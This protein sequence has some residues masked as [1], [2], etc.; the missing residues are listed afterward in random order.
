MLTKENG[1]QWKEQ[2]TKLFE[3]LLL[4]THQINRYYSS[5]PFASHLISSH[6]ISPH[7][8]MSFDCKTFPN[9]NTIDFKANNVPLTNIWRVDHNLTIH[10]LCE[11]LILCKYIVS[12][13]SWSYCSEQSVSYWNIFYWHKTRPKTIV[14]HNNSNNGNNYLFCSVRKILQILMNV[15]CWNVIN[16]PIVGSQSVLFLFNLGWLSTFLYDGIRLN[17]LW[18]K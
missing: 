15:C 3:R 10:L 11:I 5:H 12:A 18:L 4:F 17:L 6:L 16:F 7:S 9:R 1:H 2:T 8:I 13:M 14:K